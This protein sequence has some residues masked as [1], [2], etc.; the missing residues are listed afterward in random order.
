MRL[1]F[2]DNADKV[3]RDLDR[4]LE[5]ALKAR[6]RAINAVLPGVQRAGFAEI[7]S[8]YQVKSSTMSKYAST[9]LAGQGSDEASI[10]VKGKGFS[11][12]EFNPRK[13]AKGV[14]VTI[15]GRDVLFPHSF[16]VPSRFGR[17]VFARGAYGGKGVSRPSGES[18]GRFHYSIPRLPINKFYSFAPPDA[19]SNERVVAAMDAE[20]E[21]RL[22]KQMERELASIARGF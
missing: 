3:E 17:N 19:F 13:G 20:A 1:K 22:A 6:V 16:M 10:T 7:A 2:K 18:F 11:L 9:Q 4:L 12:S 8:V 14:T 5:G 15:K 21:A